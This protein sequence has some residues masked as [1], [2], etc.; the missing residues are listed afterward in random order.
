MP[1]ASPQRPVSSV[2]PSIPKT[3][4][5]GKPE[6]IKIA[7]QRA[8]LFEGNMIVRHL[9]TAQEVGRYRVNWYQ[10]SDNGTFIAQSK[11]VSVQRV[12]DVL[13]IRDMTDVK[14]EHS[15]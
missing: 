4:F 6:E 11:F 8:F 3:F 5:L 7:I 12:D 1:T 14:K 2:Q 9:Y 15:F 10:D 13:Q